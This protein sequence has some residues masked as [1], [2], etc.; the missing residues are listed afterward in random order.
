[1]KLKFLLLILTLLLFNCKNQMAPLYVGTYTSG[2]SEGIYK[3]DF[4]T[5]TGEINNLLIVAKT[6]NPSF[7]TYAPNKKYVYA[8][9]EDDNGTLSSFKIEK[10]G[11]LTFINRVKSFG[12]APCHVSVNT[13]GTKLAVSN[14]VGGNLVLYDINNDGSLSDASQIFNHNTTNEKSHAHSA[15]FYKNDL[16]VADLGR[17]SVFEYQTNDNKS[18]TLKT[19]AILDTEKNAGPRHFVLTNN[20]QFI[21]IIN[22]LNSTITAAKRVN[23]AFELIHNKSTLSEEYTGKNACADIHLSKDERFLYG[24]NR[25]ENSIAVFER[26]TETGEITKM[27][28][29]STHGDWPRNF[30]LDPTGNFLLVANKKSNNISV[31]KV[32][33][34]TGKLSF[35]KDYK[36]PTP[37]CLLF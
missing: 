9:G 20:G 12:G 26:N 1:M 24:S 27:Q 36:A 21:Y 22:E 3:I 18:Y 15:Q 29:M 19:E 6:K 11:E 13:M 23:D 10:N 31:F 4:N 33:T 30:S 14:Y 37:V 8:V 25:G 16:Y 28:N 35:L 5:K 17:N 2:E 7:I 32:D 34:N